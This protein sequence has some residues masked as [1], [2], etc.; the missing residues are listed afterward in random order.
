LLLPVV[1][2]EAVK[3]TLIPM[4]AVEAQGDLELELV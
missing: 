1:G 3:G 4:L 2:Q